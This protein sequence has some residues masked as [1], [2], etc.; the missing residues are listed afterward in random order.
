MD[1]AMPFSIDLP[2]DRAAD[3][4]ADAPMAFRRERYWFLSF[5]MMPFKDIDGRA[6]EE[7][8]PR[9]TAGARRR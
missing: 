2:P 9:K 1:A 3:H 7:A 6:V 8:P 4:A 5:M